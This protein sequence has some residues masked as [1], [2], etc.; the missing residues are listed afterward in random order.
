MKPITHLF[1]LLFFPVYLHAQFSIASGDSVYVVSG[2]IFGLQDTL[3]NN[4]RITGNGA[5]LLNS[6]SL[7]VLKGN[8][9]IN[10]LVDSATAILHNHLYINNSLVIKN[11]QSLN[12]NGN[13]LFSK[14]PVTSSG[15]IKGSPVSNIMFSEVVANSS[16][17]FDTTAANDGNSNALAT[18]TLPGNGSNTALYNKLYIYHTLAPEGGTLTLDTDLVIRS[19]NELT[20]RVAS[21]KG[22]IQYNPN[23]KFV[24][25][26]FIPARRAWRLLT[27][28]IDTAF[29]SPSISESWQ[30][31]GQSM[32]LGALSNTNPG[33][34]THVT[35]GLT[36]NTNPG[37]G[38]DVGP[39]SASIYSYNYPYNSWSLIPAGTKNTK[40][41]S[42]PGWMLFVRGDRT[43]NLSQATTAVPTNTVLRTKGRIYTGSI[44]QSGLSAGF[45]VIGNPYVSAILFSKLKRT[46]VNNAYYLWDPSIPGAFNVG[47]FVTYAWDSV[48]NVYTRSVGLSKVPEDTIQ[49]GAAFVVYS[50]ANGMIQF[51]ETDKVAGSN[52]YQYRR[53]NNR[54]LR[55]QLRT[56]LYTTDPATGSLVINDGNVVSFNSRYRNEIDCNDAKKPN[57]FAENF[58]LLSHGEKLAIER[59]GAISKRDTIFY[60]MSKMKV[61]NYRLEFIADHLDVPNKTVAFLEDIYLQQKTPVST[62]DTTRVDF[63]ITADVASSASGR[64]RLVFKPVVKKELIYANVVD[65]D[66]NVNW[67]LL[68]EEAMRSY[69]VQ[70]SVNGQQFEPLATVLAG[71][72]GSNER[73]GWL[74]VQPQ[75]GVSYYYQVKGISNSGSVMYTGMVKVTLSENSRKIY[76]LR[77]PVENN[78]IYLQM[79]NAV[80]GNYRMRLLNKAGQQVCAQTFYH[81]QNTA[82]ETL[83]ID[84]VLPTGIYQLLINDLNNK[85]TL[86][87]VMIP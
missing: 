34:G 84:K 50:A 39:N 54:V 80:I 19:T 72:A 46:D 43:I 6:P 27:T 61:K 68:T 35:G 7:Q 49:S 40:V 5:L 12:L 70:R 4:G 81:A 22:S 69:E 1:L 83:W 36:Y 52:N 32:S 2:T 26:R 3:I 23:G 31:G 60:D 13:T 62:D 65:E 57:N 86:I 15:I 71:G 74:D 59:R 42:K 56:S 10:N 17:R 82:T 75:K 47:G 14:G 18:L 44:S 8:G 21:V 85:Q 76:V 24:I 45:N 20:A 67:T 48:N 37:S 16:L 58:G 38:F 78:L 33:Y 51:E 63:S 79:T 55:N 64:F 25:E 87:A 29:I 9:S 11:G 53:I 28:P 30:E 66:I 77:N 73:F 41:N